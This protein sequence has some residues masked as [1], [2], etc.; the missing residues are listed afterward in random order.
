MSDEAERE[1]PL[2]QQIQQSIRTGIAAG[3]HGAGARLPSETALA[4]KFGTTRTTV[5][6]ALA[7]LVFEG[8]IVR[9]N[10]RGSFVA[11][12]SIHSTIDSRQCLTF[13]EQMA[14]TGRKVSYGFCSLMLTK[15]SLEVAARLRLA[16]GS[17]VFHLERV[18]LIGDRPVCLELRFL[19]R[20]IGLRVT[21]KMLASQAA[22]HFVGDILGERV[23]TIAVS[24]TAELADASVGARLAVEPGSPVLV[25]TNTHHANGGEPVMC[26]RSIYP[27]DVG[28]DYVLGQPLPGHKQPP[29]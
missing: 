21:G 27:G 15:A 1:T 26:G 12:T 7:Q 9:Q 6:Q 8:V 11:P 4:Q 19:P 13:E 2:Y 5:R 28:T 3:T 20:A 25:R 23:P 16:P 22:H 18:R 17:A 24:I 10:G 14:Q 29:D